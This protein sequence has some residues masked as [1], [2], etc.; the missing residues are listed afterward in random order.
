MRLYRFVL[1]TTLALLP[2]L[3]A[4]AQTS[5][6][7][8]S[9][10]K[11]KL[12]E[13]SGPDIQSTGRSNES[14]KAAETLLSHLPQRDA[15]VDPEL[16]A[17]N[18]TYALK[19]RREF[20]WAQNIS[21]ELFYNDVLPYAVLDET[22]DRWRPQMYEVSRKLVANATTATDAAQLLNRDLFTLLKVKY[23]TTRKKPNQNCG[24]TID[25]GVAS[26]TGLSVLL[27]NACRSVGIP[28]RVA[29]VAKWADRE[30]N[31]TWVEIHDGTSWRFC[32]AAEYDAAGLDRGWFTDAA[33]K[34]IA[35]DPFKAVWA[36]SWKPTGTSFPLVWSRGDTSVSAVDVTQRY[37]PATSAAGQANN[38]AV[39]VW[40]KRGGKRV[41]AD[42]TFGEQRSR[43]FADPDDINRTAII[44]DPGTRPLEVT[45]TFESA[46]AKV[47]V[48]ESH[49]ADAVLDV[50]FDELALTREG[51]SSSADS[52]WNT[53]VREHKQQY[54]AELEAN[55]LL[56]SGS[57]MRLLQRTFGQAP[58]TGRSLWISMHGGG[59][60]TSEVNDKQWK[61]QIELYKPDEGIY[62]APRATGD[63]WDL[64]HRPEIDAHFDRLIT[65]AAVVWGVDTRRVY[66]MGYSA[67]GDGVYQLA[68]R[69][70]DRFAAAA[71][72]A[73]H[74][75]DAAP[76]NLR[77]LPFAILMGGKDT[78]YDRNKVAQ[79]WADDL[80]QLHSQDQDGYVTFVRIYPEFGHWM[81]RKDAEVVPW[82]AG[83]TRSTWP[84]RVVYRSANVST[85]RFYWIGA[86]S[87]PKGEVITGQVRG[88]EINITSTADCD[89]ILYLH[90][91]LI[92]LN[93]PVKVTLGST[94][95][96]D[97][98]IA[99]TT[100]SIA[101][102]LAVRADPHA[103]ATAKLTLRLTKQ[104]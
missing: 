61:N 51:A 8:L 97:G 95:L 78:A 102:S 54:T 5:D 96:H 69:M 29:G 80:E 86:P 50:Y 104:Q 33:G 59:G 30:G 48:P 17:E 49:R 1:L 45:V 64:W 28:A 87:L 63:T 82:M 14:I 42:I 15:E 19:A 20:A 11:A 55:E 99:R 44:I 58:A 26:C 53:Y 41:L 77:N 71:M 2:T 22:R 101:E 66:L 10:V 35:G 16:V 52:A 3:Q 36:S 43:T 90:D 39:R 91:E 21:N 7:L 62:V 98:I 37:A 4:R 72:M 103:I 40:D 32:G 84:K 75:N 6:D 81:Q 18:I 34:A 93:Q 94:V 12:V 46:A 57:K 60:T 74:P 25:Q 70:A 85:N 47:S 73:G 76:I 27:V 92:D 100:R 88:Q 89:V 38:L 56:T 13:S 68:P 9:R 23:S 83:F 65:A 31:H 24:E 79:K 67:G